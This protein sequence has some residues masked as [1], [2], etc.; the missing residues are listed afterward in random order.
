M[1]A[2]CTVMMSKVFVKT[3]GKAHDDIPD[4]LPRINLYP[5]SKETSADIKIL[6]SN[7]LIQI[8]VLADSE[9]DSA[10]LGI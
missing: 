2:E 3:C 9:F 5:L 7:P 1:L 10:L 6:P 8:N 4:V